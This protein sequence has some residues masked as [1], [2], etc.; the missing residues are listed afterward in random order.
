MKSPGVAGLFGC[1]W[2]R[3]VCPGND[4]FQLKQE[5]GGGGANNDEDEA[6]VSTGAEERETGPSPEQLTS[7]KNEKQG[8]AQQCGRVTKWRVRSC[9]CSGRVRTVSAL[10]VAEPFKDY[11][12]SDGTTCGALSVVEE[13]NHDGSGE[14]VVE[15]AMGENHALAG[16]CGKDGKTQRRVEEVPEG[17]L[18]AECRSVAPVVRYVVGK[19][20]CANCRRA[21]DGCVE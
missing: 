2:V 11:T 17:R 15:G 18:D 8:Q 9:L 4:Q 21:D 7:P 5:V 3:E 20:L 1:V 6:G 16:K 14:D 19:E 13:E 10:T 12:E